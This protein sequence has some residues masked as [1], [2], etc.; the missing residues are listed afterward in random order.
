M[1]LDA[2]IAAFLQAS[3][4]SGQPPLYELSVTDARQALKQMTLMVDAPRLEVARFEERTIAGPNG[5]IRLRIFWPEQDAG[6]KRPGILL[7]YHGGGWVL[8]DLDTHENL[9][10]TY[11]ARGG[12]S[13]VNVDYRLAPEHKFPAGVE[14]AYAALCW[15]AE[16][17]DALG[18]NAG[19]IGVTGDSAGGNLAAVMCQL[20]KVRG[21]PAIARQILAYP[22]VSLTPESNQTY[23]SRAECGGGEYFLSQA[24]MDWLMGL[25][26]DDPA[27]V[28]DLRA[29]PILTEDLSGLPPAL[30]ITAGFDPLRDEGKAYAERLRAAGV[31]VDYHCFNGAIHGFL[32]FSGA[33]GAGREGIDLV[34]SCLKEHLAA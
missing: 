2:D 11:C 5:D 1:P 22:S 9:C 25:Y 34:V 7:H 13:V 18:G 4:D 8:G 27:Q 17:A 28:T 15:A 20:A 12:V 29:S 23:P 3:Q 21:G 24:D 30:V 16:N 31:P 26:L 14:D 19:R 33:I 6:G 10:R 32:S